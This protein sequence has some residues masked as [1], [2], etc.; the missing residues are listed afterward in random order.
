MIGICDGRSCTHPTSQPGD[1]C[2]PF[3]KSFPSLHPQFQIVDRL[4]GGDGIDGRPMSFE[5][6][7]KLAAP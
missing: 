5:M 2:L 4:H 7:S 6:D 1:G 3:F